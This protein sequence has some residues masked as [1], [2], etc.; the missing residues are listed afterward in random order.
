[1]RIETEDETGKTD[2]SFILPDNTQGPE[3]VVGL[4]L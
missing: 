4:G 2:L 3:T 1:M